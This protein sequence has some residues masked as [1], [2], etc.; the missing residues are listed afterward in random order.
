[1]PPAAFQAERSG[2]SGGGGVE[3][4]KESASLSLSEDSVPEAELKEDDGVRGGVRRMW[5]RRGEPEEV[6]E[7]F[8]L[9]LGYVKRLHVRVGR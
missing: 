9:D 7:S 2:L 1:M 3:G 5:V 4:R 6:T 8:F